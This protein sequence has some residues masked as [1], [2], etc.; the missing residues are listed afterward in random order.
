MHLNF[1]RVVCAE[2][3]NCRQLR[4]R[5]CMRIHARAKRTYA[6]NVCERERR[7]T[8]SE[9]EICLYFYFLLNYNFKTKVCNSLVRPHNVQESKTSTNP[10]HDNATTT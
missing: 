7:M 9:K 5:L 6:C 8:V 10:R 3:E 2:R 4:P 1:V